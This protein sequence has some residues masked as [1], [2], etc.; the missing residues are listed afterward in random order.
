MVVYPYDSISFLVYYCKID[1]LWLI[2]QVEQIYIMNFFTVPV[3]FKIENKVT[4]MLL[5]EFV[6]VEQP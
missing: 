1:L 3:L 4:T 2:N 6:E 5:L